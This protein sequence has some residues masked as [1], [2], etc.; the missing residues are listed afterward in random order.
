M[1]AR[2]IVVPS[3]VSAVSRGSYSRLASPTDW[4]VT[5]S[6]QTYKTTYRLKYQLQHA[7]NG[8]FFNMITYYHDYLFIP[9]LAPAAK[10]ET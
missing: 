6:L 8:T 9:V 4:S 5:H 7:T 2:H 10:I 3:V 1:Q